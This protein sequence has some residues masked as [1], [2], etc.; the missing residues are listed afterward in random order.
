MKN[1]VQ[2]IDN[3]SVELYSGSTA[4][5]TVNNWRT[6]TYTASRGQQ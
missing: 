2:I 6:V 5:R 3:G 4:A 1:F